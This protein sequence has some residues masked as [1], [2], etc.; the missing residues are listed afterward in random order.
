MITFVHQRDTTLEL[1]SPKQR[2]ETW[3]IAHGSGEGV[4]QRNKSNTQTKKYNKKVKRQ[5]Q[6][7]KRQGVY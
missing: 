3:V 4:G 5:Y 7:Y 1:K 6:N 2:K